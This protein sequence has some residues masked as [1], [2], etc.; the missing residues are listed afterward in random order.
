M[1]VVGLC[2]QRAWGGGRG[3]EGSRRERRRGRRE[4]CYYTVAGTMLGTRRWRGEPHLVGG[5]GQG[6]GA[7]SP[8]LWEPRKE[9]AE[10]REKGIVG[11]TA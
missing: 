5:R 1:A 9:D 3:A 6:I 10:S 4:S 8:R 7:R 2:L 11:A